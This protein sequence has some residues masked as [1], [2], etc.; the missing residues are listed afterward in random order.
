MQLIAYYILRGHNAD[1][2]AGLSY[3][4]K[5]FFRRAMELEQSDN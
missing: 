4:E 1:Y 5:L 3:A 2:L